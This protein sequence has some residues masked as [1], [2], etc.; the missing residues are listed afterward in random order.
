[1]TTSVTSVRVSDTVAVAIR[2]MREKGISQLPVLSKGVPVGSLSDRS[3]VHALSEAQDADALAK[4]PVGDIMG[5]PFPTAGPET[6]VDQAYPLLE[7]QPA[8][9]VVETG[10][11]DGLRGQD[12]DSLEANIQAII[13]RV[14]PPCSATDRTPAS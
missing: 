13:D 8:V 7:D 6:T 10:A 3:I 14:P 5:P 1:M 12:V 11:N 2:V 9:L 4:R